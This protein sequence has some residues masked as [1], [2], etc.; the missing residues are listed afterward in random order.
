MY[1]PGFE[2]R[3]EAYQ[4]A[5]GRCAAPMEVKRVADHDED[6]FTMAL[7]AARRALAP[8]PAGPVALL[9]ASADAP[10]MGALLADALDLPAARVAEF[11]G[12]TAGL[13]AL[14]AARDAAAHGEVLVVSADAPGG[15]PGDD[16]EHGQGAAAT[17]WLVGPQGGLRFVAEGHAARPAMGATARDDEALSGA[18]RALPADR[19]AWLAL[20]DLDRG[21]AKAA[22]AALPKAQLVP[23]SKRVGDGGATAPLLGLAAALDVAAEGS[24]VAA[25]AAEAGVGVGIALERAGP[26]AGPGLRA[27]LAER[28]E[29]LDYA[30]LARLRS[31]AQAFAGGVSQGAAVSPAHYVESLPARLR[32]EGQRC[33]GCAKAVFPPRAACQHC[34]GAAFQMLRLRGRGSAHSVVTIGRGSAPAE[35]ADQQRRAGAYDVAIVALE[36]GPRVAAM[37]A[38]PAGRLRI[39]DAVNL[40]VRRLYM[41][42]GAPRYGFK[43]KPA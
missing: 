28:V 15:D 18:A 35:F 1:L 36:E 11:R 29:P 17:A 8:T 34:G 22:Q 25:L 9:T 10:P 4:E 32:W 3:A 24:V 23:A 20:A 39:G 37:V 27:A 13:D 43:A 7:E 12:R 26:V 2:V 33:E 19:V 5:L 31:P 14:L 30:R 38:G 41:Q 16:A 42:D 6:A 40:V 21:L